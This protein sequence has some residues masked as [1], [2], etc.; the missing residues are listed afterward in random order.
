MG[1]PPAENKPRIPP[2]D[3]DPARH[4]PNALDRAAA[5]AMRDPE[6]TVDTPCG[7]VFLSGAMHAR[8]QNKA[9]TAQ[10]IPAVRGLRAPNLLFGLL[11]GASIAL[12][13]LVYGAGSG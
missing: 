5:A 11:L 2:V 6:K 8:K 9:H 4:C 10:A 13:I 12:L 3:A 1:R 7:P